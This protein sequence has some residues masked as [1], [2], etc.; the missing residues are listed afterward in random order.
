[1]EAEESII[2]S[3]LKGNINDFEQLVIRYQSFVFAICMNIIKDPLDA[4]N[5]AQESFFQAYKSLKDYQFKGFK[6]WICRI[7]TNKAI[8]YKRK[9]KQTNAQGI[10]YMD[11]SLIQSIE[12]GSNLQEDFIKEEENKRM[13]CIIKELPPKYSTIIY[14]YYNQGKTYDE[15]ALEEG[16]SSRTV[17]SRLY[18]A[19][20]LL[21]GKW[22]EDA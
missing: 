1:M 3:I 15:I 12:D 5:V 19:K 20:I 16:I 13:Q 9:M 8:D 22:K 6:T 14:K 11:E 18:R 21:R 4:E 7:A 10:I 17:E 2:N